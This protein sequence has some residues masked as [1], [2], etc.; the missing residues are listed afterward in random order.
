MTTISRATGFSGLPLIGFLARD[1]ARD[2]NIVFYLLIIALTALVLAVKIWGIVALAMS[3][4]ALVPIIFI[5]LIA[6]TRG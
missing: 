1:I 5:L 2:V 4:L 6:I 3:A